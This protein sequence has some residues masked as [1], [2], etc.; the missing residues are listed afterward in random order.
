VQVL[1]NYI[2]LGLLQFECY[3]GLVST[4]MFHVEH[5]ARA[6]GNLPSTKVTVVAVE[7]MFHVEHL[8]T[9]LKRA[10]NR[11]SDEA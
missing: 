4:A 8:L 10:A 7:G 6:V 1:K 2:S 11:L 5:S 9:E 3:L